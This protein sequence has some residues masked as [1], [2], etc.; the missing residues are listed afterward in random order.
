V[1][2]Q[3]IYSKNPEEE[4]ELRKIDIVSTRNKKTN[5]LLDH[6]Y[7]YIIYSDNEQKLS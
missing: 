5:D 6:A 4:Q 1:D 3:Q 2:K 7:L